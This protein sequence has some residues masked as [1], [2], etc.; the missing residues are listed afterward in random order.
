[1]GSRAPVGVVVDYIGYRLYTYIGYRLY[2][3]IG[4]SVSHSVSFLI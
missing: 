4:Y 2:T 1:M 3:Y